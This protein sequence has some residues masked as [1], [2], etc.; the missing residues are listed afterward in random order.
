MN[1]IVTLA[2]NISENLLIWLEKRLTEYFTLLYR[3]SFQW[4]KRKENCWNKFL[5]FHYEKPIKNIYIYRRLE[6]VFSSSLKKKI[7]FLWLTNDKIFFFCNME[8]KK[9]M[10]T[11]IILLWWS[12][13]TI[14]P[15]F[16][17]YITNINN[18]KCYQYYC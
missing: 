16:S 1:N 17:I 15:L 7:K 6:L 5:N 18:N 9:S 14:K 11:T 12:R 2:G 10:H 3:I 13:N 4:E 8:K